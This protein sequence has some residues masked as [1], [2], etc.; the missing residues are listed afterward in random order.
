MR[1]RKNIFA[2]NLLK[3]SGLSRNGEKISNQRNLGEKNA[4]A[5]I[6]SL[7]KKKGGERYADNKQKRRLGK[8]ELIKRTRALR[9]GIRVKA[10]CTKSGKS[11]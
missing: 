6:G 5:C 7:T 8:K 1:S 3:K 9:R 11:G 2:E 4:A 10:E